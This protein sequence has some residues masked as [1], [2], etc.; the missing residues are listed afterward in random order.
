MT[1]VPIPGWHIYWQYSGIFHQYRYLQ[2]QQIGAPWVSRT[3]RAKWQAIYSRSR[4]PYGITTH[5]KLVL[6]TGLEPIYNA[7]QAK[8][9]HYLTGAYCTGLWTF[10]S[11]IHSPLKPLQEFVLLIGVNRRGMF[12]QQSISYRYKLM[13]MMGIAPTLLRDEPQWE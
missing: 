13:D 12:T 7:Y 8:G 10:T 1:N 9:L 5:L 4:Y 2:Y 6:P 3:P 11:I